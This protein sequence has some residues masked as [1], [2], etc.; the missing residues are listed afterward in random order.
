MVHE[1]Q[2]Q[3]RR[4]RSSHRIFLS[5]S[6][7][8]TRDFNPSDPRSRL[9]SNGFDELCAW[10]FKLLYDGFII[11]MTEISIEYKIILDRRKEFFTECMTRTANIRSRL[12]THY[13]SKLHFEKSSNYDV[14]N[15]FIVCSFC[16]CLFS[17]ITSLLEI[18]CI[19]FRFRE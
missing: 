17:S 2:Q 9:F 10:L 15:S 7:C 4:P 3:R 5:T 18:Q 14:R 1:R 8:R 16:F 13:G 19:M 6:P 11:P 12:E